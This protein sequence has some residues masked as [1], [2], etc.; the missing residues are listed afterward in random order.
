VRIRSTTLRSPMPAEAVMSVLQRA[1]DTGSLAGKL[2]ETTFRL[3]QPIESARGFKPT[4]R[5]T[6]RT[7]ERGSEVRLV[8]RLHPVAAVAG[9][10]SLLTVAWPVLAAFTPEPMPWQVVVMSLLLGL[11]CGAALASFFND[12]RNTEKTIGQ[13]IQGR[14]AETERAPD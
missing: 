4:I 6:V 1:R 10:A 12:A 5:G 14:R 3:A 8:C 13:L 11:C 7:L 9:A 2:D